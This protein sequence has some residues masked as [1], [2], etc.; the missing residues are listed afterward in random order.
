MG[1]RIYCCCC[2]K[3]ILKDDNI[4]RRDNYVTTAKNAKYDC[5]GKIICGYCAEDLDENGLFPEE[6]SKLGVIY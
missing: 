1:N 3:Q 5:C 6:H 2:S 4:S